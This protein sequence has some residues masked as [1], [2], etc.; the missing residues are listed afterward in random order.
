MGFKS[1]ETLNFKSNKP[2]TLH[3]KP[4]LRLEGLEFRA[5]HSGL[6]SGSSE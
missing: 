5:Q 3:P 1:P 6:P 2:E 4:L